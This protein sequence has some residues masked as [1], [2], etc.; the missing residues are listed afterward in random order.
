MNILVVEDD[1]AMLTALEHCLG[2]AGYE[3]T[4]A[5]DGMEALEKVSGGDRFDLIISDIMMPNVS[6][7]TLLNLLKEFYH[8]KTPVFLISS[9]DKANVI[10]SALG[11]GAEDII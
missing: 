4:T 8:T 9:L 1:A 7:L 5:R 10:L 6:G 2:G 3:V 11:M